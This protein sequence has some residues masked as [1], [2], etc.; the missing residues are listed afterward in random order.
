[1]PELC[2][3][4]KSCLVFLSWSYVLA[5]TRRRTFLRLAHWFQEIIERH[6]SE[7]S[8]V[9]TLAMPNL[10]RDLSWSAI[11]WTL[12]RNS[13]VKPLI[14]GMV[15]SAAVA[16]WLNS[17]KAGVLHCSWFTKDNM[18]TLNGK[19][20]LFKIILK[21]PLHQASNPSLD[22]QTRVP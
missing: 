10:T 20:G 9:A 1:M 21:S 17:G 12:I 22:S 15:C 5:T 13:C 8:H 11:A 6:E 16:K 19:N 4:L 18:E 7:L 3:D 14:L 2:L